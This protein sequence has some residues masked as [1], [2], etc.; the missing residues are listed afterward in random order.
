MQYRRRHRRR[1]GDAA[2]SQRRPARRS[3]RATSSRA[4]P[5]RR[6]TRL[7][8]RLGD[9]LL[10]AKIREK[11]QARI[12]YETAKQEGKTTALL[13]QHRPNVFQMN[14]ANILPGDDVAVELRYTELLT[15]HDAVL[16]A[17]SFR[18]SSAR[19]TTR[20]RAP[21][22]ARSGSRTPLPAGAAPSDR[23]VRSSRSR[24][25]RRCRSRRSRSRSHDDRRREAAT[26]EPRRQ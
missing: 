24:S 11:Q 16:R 19:A 22:P 13:E 12:E 10:T 26:G 18:P 7:N 4:R 14:V 5:R 15:P 2:L 6:C 3:R 23:D 21:P 9:R 1:H 25:T 20:R 8:V 17:S